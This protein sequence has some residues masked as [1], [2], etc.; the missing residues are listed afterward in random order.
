[1]RCRLFVLLSLFAA[2]LVAGSA[3]A[4]RVSASSRPNVLL[5]V[6]DDLGYGDLSC[7]GAPDLR[8]PNID[9]LAAEGV[10]FSRF[11]ANSPVCSPTR[12]A[13][14]S[15]C[16]PDRVGVPGV[17]RTFPSDNWGYLSQQTPL[18]P[19]V[20]KK[21]GYHTALVGKW[22][23]GLSAPN[24]PNHRGFDHFHGFLGDMMDDYLTHRRH[25]VNY[26]RLNEREI[27]PPGH[28]TE[29]FS[30]WASDY[31]RSRK[32]QSKPFFLY[33]AYNA[34]H[35]PVQPPDSYVTRVKQR[36]PGIA[37]RRARLAALIEQMD[38]GIGRVITALKR[39]GA[40][41]NTLI[42]FTSDNGGQLSAGA[43]NGNLRGAKEDMYE[44]GI[45]EPLCAVWPG[46]IRGGTRSDRVAMAMDLFPTLCEAA[47][48]KV[49]LPCDGVSILPDLTGVQR[50]DDR[51]LFWVRREGG[52]RYQGNAVYAARRGDW[53]LVYN[54]PFASLELYNLRDDPQEKT[55]LAKQNPKEFNELSAALRAHMQDAGRVPWQAPTESR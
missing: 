32:G 36:N 48:A 29:L 50:Q 52:A 38:D 51:T 54:S 42:V 17:I 19:V 10:R 27:D 2:L 6:A 30:D 24:T 1:M 44:G 13:L 28:A 45:R 41:E 46:H 25:D 20:L 53:K 3:A 11:Y 55:D 5:I 22:H 26:M 37:D 39:S 33:L 4:G 15:G 18:L 43:S 23:L 21:A 9:A 7:Y 35:V 16:Y 47:G 8:T 34:P 14:M 49:P 40:Y 31:I 12:A